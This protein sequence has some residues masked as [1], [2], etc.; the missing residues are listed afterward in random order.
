MMPWSG[1][2]KLGDAYS[3]GRTTLG[4]LASASG[5]FVEANVANPIFDTVFA[6]PAFDPVIGQ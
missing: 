4:V 5:L 6:G 2:P 3:G 1:D